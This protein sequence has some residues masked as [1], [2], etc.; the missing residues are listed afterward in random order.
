MF[1]RDCANKVL[2]RIP[3]FDRLVI[4]LLG[5][6]RR[7]R[8]LDYKA[9]R[10]IHPTVELGDV[11]IDKN[12]SIGEG[13]YMNSGQIFAGENSQVSVGNFCAI[14]YNVH[15]KARSHDPEKPTRSGWHDTHKR[16]EK[17]I[18][19]GNHVWIGDNVFITPGVTV[20]DHAIVG[21]NS[22]VTRDVESFAIVG[23]VPARL[24][25]MRAGDD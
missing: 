16:I 24:I 14:G 9:T 17:D 12:V 1:L 11:V 13:T 8:T 7:R 19:I 3:V 4:H 23:G 22:V 10:D 5:R 20:G 6:A 21:A 18:T 25:R 2:D 15:I